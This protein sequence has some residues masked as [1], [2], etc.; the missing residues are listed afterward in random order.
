[1]LILVKFYNHFRTE[2]EV[3]ILVS[4]SRVLC[5]TVI[6]K[7]SSGRFIFFINFLIP[8]SARHLKKVSC[9]LLIAVLTTVL[10]C[11]SLKLKDFEYFYNIS[12][13]SA[14]L[15]FLILCSNSK[16]ATLKNPLTLH[17]AKKLKNFYHFYNISSAIGSAILFLF[18]NFNFEFSI[19][20]LENPVILCFIEIG[21]FLSFPSAVLIQPFWIF[22]ISARI[23]KRPQKL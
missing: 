19:S 16:L 1:M 11:V 3:L 14:I 8:E 4:S 17:F 5:F 22:K 20:D 6:F 15:N 21:E 9:W 18:S 23:R 12:D 10:C 7:Q 2:I 13:W